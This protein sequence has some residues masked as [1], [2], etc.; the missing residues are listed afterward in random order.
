MVKKPK[1]RT[2][3]QELALHRALQYLSFG[4]VFGAIL[5]PFIILGIVNFDEWFINNTEGWKVGMGAIIGMAV[6]GFA[7]FLVMA[8][9]EKE[10]KVTNGWITF[11]VIWFA[12]ALVTWLIKSI[13]EEIFWVMLFTGLGLAAAF[14]FDIWS[15]E[16]K[17][18]ADAYQKAR[19]DIK[20]ET[21]EEQARREVQEEQS[22]SEHPVD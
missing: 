9:K 11:L 10:I 22:E 12:I 18:Q 5:T 7:L 6:V 4:S 13:I 8:K 3:K 19:A 21:I 17:K 2:T 16:E 15:R 20:Q 1:K 14:G